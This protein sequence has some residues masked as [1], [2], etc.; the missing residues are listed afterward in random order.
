MT[1]SKS[2][3][4]PRFLQ[5]DCIIAMLI[6]QGKNL[7]EPSF[8]PSETDIHQK[9][10][11]DSLWASIWEPFGQ[12]KSIPNRSGGHLG[13]H[14]TSN[15]NFEGWHPAGGS[16]GCHLKPGPWYSVIYILES[17]ARFARAQFSW[18]SI[19]RPCPSLGGTGSALQTWTPL[20]VGRGGE[21]GLTMQSE[22]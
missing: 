8:A 17:S 19:W 7:Q 22:N 20:L 15:I 3:K 21:L 12:P 18:T 13:R 9:A 1:K 2:S 4:T 11:R 5:S 6:R 16:L 14:Q 10:R